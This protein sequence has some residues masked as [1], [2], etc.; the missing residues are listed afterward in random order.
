MGGMRMDREHEEKVKEAIMQ[1]SPD[2]RISCPVAREI[3]EE[4]GV[5]VSEVGR[6]INELGVKIYACELGCF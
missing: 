2:G 3:A 6:L 1:A 4:H 5:P